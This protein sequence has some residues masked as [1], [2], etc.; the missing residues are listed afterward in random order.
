MKEQRHILVCVAGMT[1]QIVTETLYAL[2]QEQR[3]R[4]DEIR[5]VTTLGGR[6]RM[7]R[8]LLTKPDGEFF[9]FC[10][11]YHIDPGNIKFDET[12]ITLLRTP[13]GLMLQDIRTK[14]ENEFAADQICELVRELTG[15][16]NVRLHASAAGGRKTM[17]IYLTAAMQ[18]FGRPQDKLSH[19]LVNEDFETHPAFF[20]IPPQPCMLD[21][22]DRQGN[23]IKRISTAEARIHLAEIPFIRLRGARSDWLRQGG[24]N[25]S[26]FVRQAQEY[27]D[28]ADSVHDVNIYL[29]SKTLMVTNRRVKLP[30]REFFIYTL[31][32]YLRKQ[33]RSADGFVSLDEIRIED[34]DAAF[35]MITRARE[36]EVGIEECN[37]VP[38]FSFVDTLALGLKHEDREGLK[39]IFLQVIARMKKR[40]DDAG[41]PSRY[42]ITSDGER[43]ALRF[44]LSVPPER[45]AWA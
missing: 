24:R 8:D 40:F 27:L 1:P 11:D 16:E 17:S 10:R 15:D 41:L 23:L 2:T 39:N 21:L 37:S 9:K 43:G 20:Y 14:E 18:L 5:I 7:L 30:E 28:L 22:K 3:E 34:L 44:G 42:L 4:V 26:D 25:Y 19:V 31:L 13:D 6:D 32:A 29:L 12:T 35:R 33:Q 36:A 45:L 38:R